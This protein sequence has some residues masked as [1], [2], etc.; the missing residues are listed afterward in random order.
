M[1]ADD[2]LYSLIDLPATETKITNS[3]FT[4]PS[5]KIAENVTVITAGDIARINAHTLAD[6]LQTVPGIQLEQVQ[7]PVSNNFFAI[8][9]YINRHVLVLI[10]G[11][12]QN[13]QSADNKAIPGHIPVQ[14]IDRVEIV[15]GAASTVWG[16]ALGGV[17][18]IITKSPDSEKPVSGIASASIGERKSTDLQSELSGTWDQFG[19][20]L[21]GGNL[22]SDGLVPGNRVNFNHAFG[23]FTYDLPIKG[24]FTLGLD[25]RD[26]SYGIEDVPN[27][28]PSEGTDYHDTGT[29]RYSTSHLAF[30]YPL[31]DRLSLELAGRIGR[32]E[33]RTTQGNLSTTELYADGKIKEDFHSGNVRLFWGDNK[34]N[35]AAGMEY[36]QNKMRGDEPYLQYP[37]D[38]FDLTFER[39]STYL[40]GAWSVGPFTILPGIRYDHY[41][42]FENAVSYNLGATWLLTDKTLLRAYSANGYGLPV[43]NNV[44]IVNNR[45]SLQNIRTVQGGFETS[46]IPYFWLKGTYFYNE[47]R[48]IQE[49]DFN[50]DPASF[51]IKEQIRQGFEV[52]AKT[53]PLY[54]FALA[55]GY[56]YAK[57]EDRDTGETLRTGYS[58]LN[59]T[60]SVK[61]ALNYDNNDLG[62]RGALNGNYV[63]W[64]AESDQK[65]EYKDCIWNLHLTQKL[66]P[67]NDLSPELFFT[68]NNI[69]NGNQYVRDIRPNAPR[70]IEG[71]VRFKF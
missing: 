16:Q 44:S 27:G 60:N 59:P 22:H 49:P 38:N 7:T 71:G 53:S 34:K 47:T 66:A 23:K 48:N 64:N 55:G 52:E 26:T 62:M 18:N 20:Y 9:N 61:L 24:R 14:Q 68:V 25:Y 43:V 19:Y 51:P 39:W 30:S 50:T 41:N 42:L 28:D 15:K 56:T 31:A 6:V 1:G 45:K 63:W 10:D 40:N 46:E 70:W 36:E 69:F 11:V 67:K 3:R 5:S 29:S 13:F 57:A 8:H 32:R 35:L 21:T 4:R 17:I 12:P 33:I 37:I 2:E 54:G 65:A 58:G